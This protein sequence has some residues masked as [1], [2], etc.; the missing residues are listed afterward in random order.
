MTWGDIWSTSTFYCSFLVPILLQY[1][2]FLASCRM[3]LKVKTPVTN[4]PRKKA[5]GGSCSKLQHHVS[6]AVRQV[7]LPLGAIHH[8]SIKDEVEVRGGCYRA[9][10]D[11]QVVNVCLSGKFKCLPQSSNPSSIKSHCDITA[12][13]YWSWALWH[14]SCLLRVAC[15]SYWLN[16]PLWSIVRRRTMNC[17]RGFQ[18]I[19]CHQPPITRVVATCCNICF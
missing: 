1:C 13:A 19:P 7:M 5:Q 12:T 14:V 8:G 9:S 6:A 10:C 16:L 2:T 3:P 18:L 15:M 4:L 17:I 11:L